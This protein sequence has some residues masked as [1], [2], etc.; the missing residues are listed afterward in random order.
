MGN[1][2]VKKGS[3]NDGKN[4]DQMKLR[5]VHGL[6]VKRRMLFEID[7]VHTTFGTVLI[8]RLS[9]PTTGTIHHDIFKASTLPLEVQWSLG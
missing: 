8:F 2:Q 4:N 9:K 6:L 1:N 3:K 5:A 7:H